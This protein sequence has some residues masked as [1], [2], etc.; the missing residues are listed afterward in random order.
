MVVSE[1]ISGRLEAARNA[2]T[3]PGQAQGRVEAAKK[4]LQRVSEK[5]GF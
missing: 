5:S 1:G 4:L 3:Q 2:E